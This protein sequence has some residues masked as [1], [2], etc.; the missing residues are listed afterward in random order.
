MKFNAH[1]EVHSLM[2]R[3][4]SI[5]ILTAMVIG[6]FSTPTVQAQIGLTTAPFLRI[7][8]DART[9]SMG[10]AGVTLYD[11]GIGAYYN[12]AALAWQ[13]GVSAGFSYS[14]WMAGISDDYRFNRFAST[15]ALSRR[16]TMAVEL[17][18]L[19]L[20]KQQARDASNNLMGNFSNYQMSSGVTLGYALTSRVSFGLGVKHI[21]SSIGTGQQVMGADVNPA[22][23]L[24]ADAGLLWRSGTFALAGRDSEVRLGT[25][26][27]NVG[28]GLSYLDG[29]E[30]VSLPQ[31]F[32]AGLG[33]THDLDTEGDHSFSVYSDVTRLLARMESKIVGNDTIWTSTPPLQAL[34]DGWGSLNRFNGQEMVEL[35]FF[36]Q[37]GLSVGAEY[38]FRELLAFRGG[39]YTEHPDNGDRR[40]VTFGAGLRVLSMEVDFSY[41]SSLSTDH[42]LDGTMRI[43]MR[44]LFGN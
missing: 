43:S 10:G 33:F 9:A 36:D 25:S 18:Y 7:E 17:T 27:S 5:I 16:S 28:P 42:P 29:Q 14:N 38:W 35:G 32:R 30:R 39:Y 41:L 15:I 24:A 4:L 23:T 13:R 44:F 40:Y 26:M 22:W 8:P 1:V 12:P 37:F 11:S 6:G 3:Y 19:N 2:K 20:G 21:Y 31:V 34:L